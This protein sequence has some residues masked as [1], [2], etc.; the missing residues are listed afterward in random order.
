MRSFLRL[1]QVEVGVE[2]RQALTADLMLAR[3]DAEP[4]RRNVVVR[5]LLDSIGTVPGVEA[6]GAYVDQPFLG[7]GRREAFRVEG[8]DD[9]QP[10][11]GHAASFNSVS[12]RFFEAMDMPPVRG[13]VFDGQDTTANAPV[14]VVNETMARRFWN[15][16]TAID[17]RLP[18]LLRQESRP[19]AHHRRCG[20]GRA[21]SRSTHGAGA[22]GLRPRRA[23]LL[24]AARRIDL[25]RRQ[26]DGD[27]SRAGKDDTVTHSGG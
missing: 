16:D 8:H 17:K 24:Q 2:A 10:G 1:Q 15:G 20:P 18:V 25:R 22:A 4:P 12:G 6:V 14:A 26:D 5:Q 27:S 19:L 11:L 21:L 9:L 3:R 23:T 7:G 13:R